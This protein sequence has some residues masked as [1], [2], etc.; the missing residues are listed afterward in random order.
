MTKLPSFCF[1]KSSITGGFAAVAGAC[2]LLRAF[3]R[4]LGR[5]GL[6]SSPGL[7]GRTV[8]ATFA[9]RR[10]GSEHWVPRRRLVLL[11]AMNRCLD[12]SLGGLG[13]V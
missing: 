1:N 5:A 12:M 11:K 13:G 7:G 10:R 6:L 4:F 9:I 3:A 2:G 8:R